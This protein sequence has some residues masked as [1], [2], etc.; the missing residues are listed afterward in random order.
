MKMSALDGRLGQS[1]VVAGMGQAAAGWRCPAPC[2]LPCIVASFGGGC[3]RGVRVDGL[4]QP[5]W[6]PNA[7]PLRTLTCLRATRASWLVG[8][9]ACGWSR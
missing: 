7:A 8:S 4:R 3:V 9:S 2:P 6:A 5:L 1:T